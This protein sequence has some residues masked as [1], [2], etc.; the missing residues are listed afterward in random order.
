MFRDEIVIDIDGDPVAFTTFNL[1]NNNE[2][3]NFN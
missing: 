3:I 1:K 2:L